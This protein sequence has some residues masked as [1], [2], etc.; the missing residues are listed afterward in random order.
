MASQTQSLAKCQYGPEASAYGT[1]AAAYA[2]LHK[3]QSSTITRDN[4]VTYE[5]GT[6]EGLNITKAY[7][8]PYLGNISVEYNV[9]DFDF[10]QHWVGPKTGAGSVG[11]PYIL[12]EATKTAINSQL[13][14]FSFERTNDTESTKTVQTCLGSV[15]TKFTLSGAIG[16]G[17][18]CSAQA[19]C[20]KVVDSTS[21]ETFVVSTANS[22]QMLNGTWKWGTTPTAISGVQG[23]TI[24]LTNIMA[25]D[26]TRDISS[27]FIDLPQLDGREY[28]FTIAIK[29]ANA[30][31][32]TIMTD[33][34]G[35]GLT[36][37][38]GAASV[39]P[40]ANLEFK[41]ELASGSNYGTIDIDECTIDNI[42]E[43]Q[44]L[45]GGLVILNISGTAQKGTGNVPLSW[46]SV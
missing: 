8:G 35:G 32:S 2:E 10:L 40:T 5:R 13:Q 16:L 29:M 12:T 1:E 21:G 24:T 25:I 4:G 26:D 38:T 11:D 19:V 27:R 22:L 34:S 36:P 30:L 3:T 46:W 17:L 28:K 7:W 45:N 41:I 39:N 14:P 18:V 9:E 44:T 31:A 33:F 15:G 43:T 37:N 20:Q 23:F 42:T 6:G